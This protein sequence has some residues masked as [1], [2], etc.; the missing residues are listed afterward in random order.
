MF[1]YVST[2]G[3]CKAGNNYLLFM[4]L[5][6]VNQACKEMKHQSQRWN[7]TSQFKED[8]L[9]GVANGVVAV[10]VGE[11]ERGKRV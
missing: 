1:I 2:T 8:W 10:R 5:S 6:H 4:Y 9:V 11:A 7:V 3:N